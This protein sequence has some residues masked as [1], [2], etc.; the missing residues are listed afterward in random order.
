MFYLCDM[1]VLF[2]KTGLKKHFL[3]LLLFLTT[4]HV[5]A[6]QTEAKKVKDRPN[7]LLVI[8]DDQS[9]PHASA[10]GSTFVHTP[11][12]DKVAQEGVLFHHAFTPSPSC[13]PTRASILTGR[14]IWQNRE[15]GVHISYFPRDLTV[16]PDL[17]EKAGYEIGYTGKGWGPG[18]W[19]DAG[20]KHNP[21]GIPFFGRKLVPPASGISDTDYASNFDDFL[22]HREKDKPFYFWCGGYEPHRGYEWQSGL[23]AG[24]KLADVQAPSFLLDNDSTRADL[25]DYALEI[26]WFDAQLDRMLKKLAEIGELD[27]TL[28]IVTS[29]NGMPFPR[30]KIQ[31]YEY[32]THVPLAIRWGKQISGNRQVQDMVSLI[33]LAPTILEACKVPLPEG[34]TGKSLMNVL[35]SD[36]SGWVDTSRTI[37]VTGKERHNY[38]RKDNMGYPIRA[39]RTKDYLYIRN[40][41]TDRWPAGDPPLYKDGEI[42][43]PSGQTLLAHQHDFGALF[44]LHVAKRQKDE[45]YNIVEDPGC[46]HNLVMLPAYQSVRQKLAQELMATLKVQGDPRA[47]GQGDIFDSYPAFKPIIMKDKKGKSLFPG[48]SEL[49]QYNPHFMPADMDT[50]SII[51]VNQMP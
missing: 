1:T 40:F 28:I 49:G 12:F 11:A 4:L 30:A 35:L 8:A 17:L 44:S 25:L 16:F 3:Y 43:K 2:F 20:W 32:S 15:A 34:I 36:Q 38:S 45:L 29:D 7:V 26:E 22:A 21:A 31:L 23:K 39:L 5:F 27:N 37:V 18:N 41:R 10:Y 6:Q 46:I 24:K 9:W 50:I 14:N 47:F 33:D 51:H 19:K 13:S 48:F 42:D